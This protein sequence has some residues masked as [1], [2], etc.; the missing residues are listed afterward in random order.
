M[1]SATNVGSATRLHSATHVAFDAYSFERIL[2]LGATRVVHASDVLLIGPSRRNTAEHML[3]RAAWWGPSDE[4]WDQLYS[5]DVRWEPP[6]VV[7]VSVNPADRVNLW[8]TCSRLRDVGL[9]HSDVLIIDMERAPRGNPDYNPL[10]FGECVGNHRDDALLLS[11]LA[12]ARPFPRAR[13]DRAASLWEQYVDPDFS[14][15]ARTCARGLKGFPDLASVWASI[16]SFLPRMTAKGSLHPSLFDAL[17]LDILSDEWQ[18]PVKVM[19]DKSEKGEDLRLFVT[20]VGDVF[21]ADRL[22]HWAKHSAQPAVERAPG[23]KPDNPMLS[24]IYRLTERGKHL[25]MEGLSQLADAPPL[26]IAGI[27]A[28][29]PGSPWVLREGGKVVRL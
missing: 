26:P 14:R 11:R 19:V 25:R 29:A 9:T 5:P 28:Y 7:W 10:G 17:I 4:A 8:R 15:F 18:T 1:T 13:Y 2:K 22:E 12:V 3:S 21:L 16:S 27:E 24:L 23:P 6:V 20:C